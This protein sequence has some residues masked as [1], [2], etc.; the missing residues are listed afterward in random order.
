LKVK[1]AWPA[2]RVRED[3]DRVRALQPHARLATHGAAGLTVGE[4]LSVIA[5]GGR[6]HMVEASCRTALAGEGL[7]RVAR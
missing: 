2:P 7:A 6:R 4:L 1:E 5:G 3:E